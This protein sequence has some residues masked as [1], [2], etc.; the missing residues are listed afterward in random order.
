MNN[1]LQKNKAN[2]AEKAASLSMSQLEQ[3]F[4]MMLAGELLRPILIEAA[5]GVYRSKS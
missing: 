5:K 2:L 1:Q 4:T 3:L